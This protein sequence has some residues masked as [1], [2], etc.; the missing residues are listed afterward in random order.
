VETSDIAANPFTDFPM[1]SRLE[2]GFILSLFIFNI[3]KL[4]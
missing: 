4:G 1:N 3:T 2:I